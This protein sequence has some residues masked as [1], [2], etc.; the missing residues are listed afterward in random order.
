MIQPFNSQIFYPKEKE[1]YVHTKI[2]TRMFIADLLVVSKKEKQLKCSPTGKWISKFFFIHTMDQ[3]LIVK[4]NELLI[5]PTT[6]MNFKN[7]MLSERGQ[8]HKTTC[9]MV[10]FAGHFQKRQNQRA[11]KHISGCLG[12]GVGQGLTAN[13][14]EGTFSVDASILKLDGGNGYTIVKIY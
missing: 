13:G 1:I 7:T 11:R 4:R 10:L 14:H 9:F 6:Q 3:Y 8:S 12:Q 5:H 2:S